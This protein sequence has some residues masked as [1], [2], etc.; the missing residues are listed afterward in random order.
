MRLSI[1]LLQNPIAVRDVHVSF[2][3]AGNQRFLFLSWQLLFLGAQCATTNTY[4]ASIPGLVESFGSSCRFSRFLSPP[5]YLGVPPS[6]A[7]ALLWRAVEVANEARTI[8]QLKLRGS[9]SSIVREFEEDDTTTSDPQIDDVF[10][11]ADL[12]VI[13]S[14][15]PYG[16]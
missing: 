6:T 15:G 12:K 14:C 1:I 2:F 8:S 16:G 11:N 5:F 10:A 7:A 13:R 4:Q 9:S 3:D